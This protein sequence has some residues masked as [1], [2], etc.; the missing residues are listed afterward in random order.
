V[1]K[2]SHKNF[3]RDTSTDATAY[4]FEVYRRIGLAGRAQIAFEL[5]DALREITRSGIRLRHPEYDEGEVRLAAL[6]LILGDELFRKLFNT[7][8][9]EV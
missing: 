3:P 1:I 2:W 5:S 6:R 7:L 8:Q 9:I 4:Q